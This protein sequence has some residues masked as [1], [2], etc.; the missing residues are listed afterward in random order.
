MKNLSRFSR[1]Q[2][3]WFYSGASVFVL[4]TVFLFATRPSLAQNCA[5]NANTQYRSQTTGDWNTPATWQC[6]DDGINWQTP[7]TNTP[8][9][10]H[11][12]TITIRSGDNITVSANVTVD[13]VVIDSG[14]TVTVNAGHTWTV[15]NGAGTD[16]TV[17]GTVINAGKITNKGA[18]VFNASSLYQHDQD[19]GTI[20]TATW[21]VASTV[22]V[23]GYVKGGGNPAVAGLNQSFGNFTWNNPGQT[24]SPS[25]NGLLTT[26]GGNLTIMSTGTSYLRLSTNTNYTLNIGGDL[27]VSGGSLNFSDTGGTATVNITGSYNQAGGTVYANNGAIATTLNFKGANETFTQS[28]GTLTTT[29]I[30]FNVNGAASL[31]LSNDLTIAGSRTLTVSS[32][33]TLNTGAQTVS[34]AGT[35]TLASG[36]TLGIGSAA[37]ITSSGAT[38]N[39]QATTRNFSTGANY[40]YNGSSA[41]VTGNGLPATIGDLTVNNSLGVVLT[42]LTTVNGAL[43][44]TGTL[45]V[46][47]SVTLAK[48]STGTITINGNLV[49]NGSV[50]FDGGGG[51]CR[52]ADPHIT[53]TSGSLGTWSGTG[54]FQLFNVSIDHQTADSSLGGDIVAFGGTDNGNNTH[55]TINATCN[56]APTAIAL[57]SFTATDFTGKVLLQWSTGEEVGNLGFHLYREENGKFTRLTPEPVA[58]SALLA[59]RNVTLRAGRS[60][61]WWD[62]SLQGIQSQAVKYW[63]EDIDLSGKRKSYGPVTPVPSQGPV[64]AVEVAALLSRLAQIPTNSSPAGQSLKPRLSRNNIESLQPM[65]AGAT[66]SPQDVQWALAGGMAVKLFV[67][68]EGWYSVTQPELT[69][70]GLEKVDPR[71]LQLFVDGQEVAILVTGQNDGHFDSGDAIEFYGTGLDT[72][73]TDTRTYW[74]VVGSNPGK[75]VSK[76]AA[77][78][79]RKGANVSSFL[80]EVESKPRTIYFSALT[81]GEGN[82]KFFGPL[83]STVA[84]NPTVLTL[85]V[86]HADPSPSALPQLQV[87]LQGVMDGQHAV[88]VTLNDQPLGQVT[89]TEQ[90]QGVRSFEIAQGILREGENQVKLVAT[91]GDTDISLVDTLSLSYYHTFMADDNALKFSASGGTKVTI[92]GFDS[93]MIWVMDITDPLN[94]LAVSGQI[95]SQGSSYQVSITVPGPGTRTLMAFSEERIKD[96]A[97]ITANTP[98]TWNSKANGA[99]MVIISHSDFLGSLSPLKQ[100]RESQGYS[101]VLID[102]EDLY[103]EF[104]FGDKTPQ[105]LK[106]FL[107]RASTTW[108][109]APRFVLLMGDGSADPRNYLGYGEFD[110]VPARMIETKYNETV[111]DD[112]FV[113]FNGDGL[114]EMAIGRIPVRT[115]SDAAGVIAKIAG[116]GQSGTGDWAKE[117][118]LVSDLSDTFDFEGASSDVAVLLPNSVTVKKIFRSSFVNDELASEALFGAINQGVLLVN[119]MGHGSETSWRGDLITT[120]DASTLTNGLNLPFF[121]NMTCWNGW[122][123]DPYMETLGKGLLNTANG[124]AVAVWASS[125]LTEPSVQAVMNK[126]LIQ[127]LFSGQS[128]T[129]GEAVAKA[130]AVVTDMDVRRTWI[131]FGDPTTTLK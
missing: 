13:Q 130:K 125:G 60:Y 54:A 35:F 114:P 111:S 80:F 66:Q 30:N 72:P 74:L 37:G 88:N 75:R 16:L 17:N 79:G 116:Y 67:Q 61:S 77:G 53:I 7:T 110:L 123:A 76:A 4:A 33:G 103:D 124:G 71:K 129:I 9:S 12:G 1:F 104:S 109:K 6:S 38:G 85:N 127:L 84:A 120:D 24:A 122:F 97:G 128:L 93:S 26:V 29:N 100:F 83:I 14:G 49:N 64:P 23:I 51:G 8:T 40:T 102:V 3:T 11:A 42:G 20:P 86:S 89:F 46:N 65:N 108:Q 91:G 34:G 62:N 32:G 45:T 22:E 131:L 107:T 115:S 73:S 57:K 52:D 18:I 44:I 5:N 27:I 70:Y 25:F 55:F 87:I 41:Q 56:S 121:V 98:S 95:K 21:N 96:V 63:L 43:N 48:T 39:I 19:G 36:G 112:W 82:N 15:A 47:S 105:A 94:V 50:S 59:G 90:N 68:E 69:A 99:D 92:G 31:S 101:V 126:Q 117:I 2:A 119:Y 78:G 113:D 28:G 58:G 81:N 10:G 106:D 118:L